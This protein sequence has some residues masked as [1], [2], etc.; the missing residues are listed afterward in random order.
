[1]KALQ[2]VGKEKLEFI[3]LPD[4]DVGDTEVLLKIK[5]VGICGT[6]LH[7]YHGGMPELPVP[8]VLGHEFVGDVVAVG[9]DVT[10]VSVGERATA[11]HVTGCGHCRHCLNARPN[12]CKTPRV[13]GLHRPGALAEYM[14]IPANLVY[15]LPS[16]MD[17]DKGVLVEPL[18]IAV[19]AVR[20][21][22]IQLGDVACVVGQGPIGLFMDQVLKSAGVVVY[23]VD[24]MQPRLDY[25][26]QHGFVD[27][28]INSKEQDAVSVLRSLNKGDGADYVYEAVG[29]EVTMQLALKMA[30]SGGKVLVAGV[31][32]QP[33]ALDM[34]QIVKRELV[35]EGTWTC[36]HAFPPTINLLKSERIKTE[37]MI[38]HR[39]SFND[40]VKAFE[41]A[42]SYS[43]N[44][45]K[46][47]IEL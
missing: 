14:V 32:E 38:T 1:M 31:F 10:N 2:Y 36:V 4:P 42:S 46:S 33:A 24:V 41:D 9:K 35:V 11:E 30:E 7:I 8:L 45:I 3:E 37:G 44:R 43:D 23:G 18:S 17:Y 28:V 27:E 15:G 40:A 26:K 20:K 29:R 25:A 5:Q 12:I 13:Y 21:S 39:Y 16:G 47:V 34:M 19:Y 6:D 22:G